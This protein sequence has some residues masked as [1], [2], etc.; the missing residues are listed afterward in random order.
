MRR[1]SLGPCGGSPPTPPVVGGAAAADV[2]HRPAAGASDGASAPATPDRDR[3]SRPH[4]GPRR[5][6]L[7]LLPRRRRRARAGRRSRTR[8]ST[9]ST[10][11]HPD[12]HLT[13][14]VV[15][16]DR[17]QR[18]AR[19]PRSRPATAPTS[20]GRSASAAP[21]AFHGQWLDLAP[22]IDKTNYDLTRLPAATRRH[23]QARRGPGRHP[24]RD[25]PVGP[26]L[27]DEPVRGGRPRRAAARVR[28][29]VQDARRHRWSTGTTTRS[30]RSP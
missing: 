2:E 25:L 11:S 17:R 7:V 10:P 20:S 16:Y 12:I 3:R 4:A 22:L 23:L 21:N 15:T 27:Q 9:T 8:S 19:R 14:E 18:R 6:P 1:S 30:A 5:D 29:P 28:R 13:F 24:V 26:V